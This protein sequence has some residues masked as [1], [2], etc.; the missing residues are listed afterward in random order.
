ELSR[1]HRVPVTGLADLL[2]DLKRRLALIEGKSADLGSLKKAAEQTRAA[3]REAAEAL[4]TAR[5][6]AAKAMDAAV[7]KE[8]P[9]VK[10]EKARFA[11]RI[12]TL[13]EADWGEAGW[14]RVQFQVATNPGASPGPINRIA[15]GGEL[16]RFML[17]LKVTLAANQPVPTLVFDE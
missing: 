15:S 2:A 17:A 4:G 10:L 3:Y 1:K 14:D 9:P 12:E 11:T 13:P 8:L 7:N 5:A 6:K 16:A